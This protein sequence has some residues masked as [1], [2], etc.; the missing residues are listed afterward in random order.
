MR[1]FVFI[2]IAITLFTFS[3]TAK[4]TAVYSI[5][6]TLVENNVSK[7]SESDRIDILA[8]DDNGLLRSQYEDSLIQIIWKCDGKRFWF[9]LLNK[10]NY[11]ITIDWDNI[12]FV[13]TD[14]EI[15]NVIHSG[16]KYIDRNNGQLKTIVPRKAKISDFLVPSKNCVFNQGGY[17]TIGGWQENYLFPCVYKNQKTL[18]R[19]AP[20]FIGKTMRID[21][22]M[23]IGDKE[24]GYSFYFELKDLLNGKSNKRADDKDRSDD[25]YN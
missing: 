24:H 9:N 1:K 25:I 19:D 11:P 12:V 2:T 16:T 13:D 17:F 6:L 15:G 10:T 20:N 8:S 5:P 22:P 7:Y 23:Q 18:D 4:K 21:M 14:S 3:I